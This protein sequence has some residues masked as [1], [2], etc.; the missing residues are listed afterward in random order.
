[1]VRDGNDMALMYKDNDDDPDQIY[2]KASLGT[3]VYWMY[4]MMHA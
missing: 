2:G 4:T 1:M 3:S